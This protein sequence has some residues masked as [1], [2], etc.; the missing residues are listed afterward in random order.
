MDLKEW[1]STVLLGSGPSKERHC[2]WGGWIFT[3]GKSI[4]RQKQ[5]A[6]NQCKF[7]LKHFREKGKDLQ[8]RRHE[9]KIPAQYNQ[10]KERKKSA[11][12]SCLTR[13]QVRSRR[14][15]LPMHVLHL[16]TALLAGWIL[17]ARK[18][19]QLMFI[20]FVP[21]NPN[22]HKFAFTR[23]IQEK[24]AGCDD[25]R[26]LGTT[27]VTITDAVVLSHIRYYRPQSPRLRAPPA[28]FTQKGGGQGLR[29]RQPP[30]N[31]IWR[32]GCS[33]LRPSWPPQ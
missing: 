19:V 21:T 5:S 7:V 31:P 30:K 26:E 4:V 15:S 17:G 3:C 32:G 12:T 33:G 28:D 24:K 2:R 13:T 1:H 14:I 16:Y 18:F 8:M 6:I 20:H 11:L 29:P 27:F 9:I 25:W 22:K 10:Y 23:G